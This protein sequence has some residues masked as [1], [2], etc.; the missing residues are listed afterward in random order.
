MNAQA[1]LADNPAIQRRIR[2]GNIVPLRQK[3]GKIVSAEA[4]A[5]DPRRGYALGLMLIDGTITKMQHDAGVRYGEDMA[6]FYALTGVPFPSAR[7]QNLFSVRSTG[8]D[9]SESRSQAAVRA[10][11][12]A[13]RLDAL[14]L[15]VGDID[16]ARR[17][18][19]TVKQVCVL[20]EQNARCWPTHMLDYLRKG[21]NAL[22]RQ[23]YGME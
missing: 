21:L 20:D 22:A 7:A 23:H 1:A 17:V 14:L 12:T 2:E 11:S 18:S 6:R 15:T 8:Q 5:Q 4:Q 19:H 13:K 10:R 16:T 9:E 3:D